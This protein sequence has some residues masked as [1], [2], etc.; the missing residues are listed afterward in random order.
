[1]I[2]GNHFMLWSLFPCF[3]NSIEKFNWHRYTPLPLHNLQLS[4]Y[5]A[6]NSAAFILMIYVIFSAFL[7][8]TAVAPSVVVIKGQKT[9]KYLA[10]NGE[11]SLYTSP[12][13]N[14]DCHF[15]ERQMESKYNTY[16]SQ[17][18]R[19]K[20]WYVALKKNGKPEL[21]P[22]TNIGRKAIL[23]LPRPLH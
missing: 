5:L 1:M 23:F 11:G 13:A 9:G 15:L 3:F 18:Y 2:K 19:G 10:M 16:Q 20:S 8:L 21:G 14:D 4:S 7:Q 22:N 17:K 12:V 6:A